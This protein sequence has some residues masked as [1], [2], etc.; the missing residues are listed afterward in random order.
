MRPRSKHIDK[1][2]AQM[3]EPN[4]GLP[5]NGK[6]PSS[7]SICRKLT[8]LPHLYVRN[9]SRSMHLHADYYAQTSVISTERR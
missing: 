3:R 7:G 6:F 2:L 1:F 8:P 9:R 4:K 5:L